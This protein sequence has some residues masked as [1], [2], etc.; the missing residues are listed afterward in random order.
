VTVPDLPDISNHTYDLKVYVMGT[1][2]AQTCDAGHVKVAQQRLS[3]K[4]GSQH[5]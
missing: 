1:A 4:P 3:Q 5:S 2:G